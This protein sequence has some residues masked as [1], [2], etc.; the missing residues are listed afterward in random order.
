MDPDSTLPKKRKRGNLIYATLFLLFIA[1]FAMREWKW[2]FLSPYE[3]RVTRTLTGNTAN[4]PIIIRQ[5]STTGVDTIRSEFSDPREGVT[6]VSIWKI[7]DTDTLTFS[8]K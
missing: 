3:M 8:A 2:R 1:F 6:K 5:F 4:I 7:G